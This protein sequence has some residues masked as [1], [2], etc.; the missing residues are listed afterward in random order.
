MCS[1]PTAFTWQCLC[2]LAKCTK[3]AKGGAFVHPLPLHNT[4]PLLR[5]LLCP[6]LLKPH[7]SDTPPAASDPDVTPPPT[8]PPP[9]C[10]VCCLQPF[11]LTRAELL[12]VLNLAPVSEVEVHLIVE[13]CEERLNEQ[14]VADLIAVI[15]KHLPRP[16]AAE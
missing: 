13:E 16:L 3:G 6:W 8:A 14:Q 9:L 12:Q 1:L 7:L 11:G 4:L 5:L 2:T 10:Y 15:G